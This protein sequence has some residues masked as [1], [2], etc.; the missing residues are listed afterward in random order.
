MRRIRLLARLNFISALVLL[1]YAI[2]ELFLHI[3]TF[4][5]PI[6]IMIFL[7]VVDLLLLKF[8][9]IVAAKHFAVIVVSTSISFFTLT[10]GD[11][12]SEALFIPLVTM[13][14]LIF[15]NKHTSFFYIFYILLLIITV[16]ITQQYVQPLVELNNTEQIFFKTMN[17]LSAAVVTYLITFYFKSEN[18]NFET[19]IIK[20]HDTVAEKNKEITDSIRY[21]KRI[22]ETLL[23]NEKSIEKWLNNLKK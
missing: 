10:T 18:E 2:A 22:Q 14:L 7:V 15:K 21:A 9:K 1:I 20:M 5:L 4:L 6:G 13:P 3:Y 16:K 11:N 23:P 8:Q 12:Y 19:K 17:T